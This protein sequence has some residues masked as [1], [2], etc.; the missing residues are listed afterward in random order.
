MTDHPILFQGWKVRTI[1]NWDFD[2]QGDMQTRRVI[3]NP[4]RLEGLMLEGEA[5]EWC[6]YGKPG[7]RLW[8]RETWQICHMFEDAETGYVDEVELWK[9]KIPKQK[10]ELDECGRE[11]WHVVYDADMKECDQHPDDRFV[12]RYRPSI[13]MPRWASRILLEVTDIRIQRVKQ[14]LE[15]DCIAEGIVQVGLEPTATYNFGTDDHWLTPGNAF[16]NLWDSINAKRGFG[17]DENP[18]VWVVSFKRIKP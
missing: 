2:A 12:E 3:K 16:G 7:D 6:P 1:L 13:H 14:I 11:W 17:W 15:K 8:V 10:P 4:S 5:S 9:G 18:W